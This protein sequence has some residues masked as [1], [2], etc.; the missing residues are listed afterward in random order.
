M[1]RT[2][3]FAGRTALVTGASRG[4]GAAI[5]ERLA[6]EG[7]DVAITARTRDADSQTTGTVSRTAGSLAQ[8]LDRLLTH[9]GKAVAV[10]A[11]LADPDDRRRIVPEA[12]SAFGGPIDILVNNAAANITGRPSEISARHSGTMFEV[13]VFAPIDLTQAVIPGMRELGAGWILN[14]SSGSAS[15]ASGP[16]PFA[17]SRLLSAMG[18]YGGSKAALNRVSNAF[19]VELYGSAI[20]VNTL[21]PRG[22]VATDEAIAR[23]MEGIPKDWIEP[24]EAM[25][26]AAAALC[27]CP[28][29][30]TGLVQVSLEVIAEFGLDIR[31]LDGKSLLT[32]TPE[33][34]TST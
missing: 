20:R 29:E 25:A 31:A 26:E 23:G 9:G 7:A 28:I 11:D 4:I 13:N 10:P 1:M 19:A 24:V 16:P 18:M 6:A 15:P 33:V 17:A 34:T 21:E 2:G 3:R 5:A 12:M 32:V 27:D 14:I 8:V 22:A 30:R